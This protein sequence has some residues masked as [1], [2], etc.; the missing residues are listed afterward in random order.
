MRG[1][2]GG[3]L[4]VLLV[5]G[6][7]GAQTPP[8]RPRAQTV[9][10]DTPT[11]AALRV[12]AN[13][14]DADAQ[15]NLGVMYRIGS[16]VPQD[17]AQSVAWYRKAADQGHTFAQWILGLMYDRGEGVP[18][19]YGQSVA[20]FRKAADQGFARAQA[21]LGY[22]YSHGQGVPQDYVES[23]K[24]RNLAASRAEPWNQKAYAE[25]RDAMAKLMTPAQLAAAQTLAR[26]WLAAFQKR[27]GK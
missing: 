16:G 15:W 20:W 21:S 19:D 23:H 2:R 17:Y 22:A 9:S 27:G 8:V 14:G 25:A 24:W 5:S 1:V 11:I 26:E 4:A 12:K 6:V 18:Q 10:T 7:A 3:M 13:A